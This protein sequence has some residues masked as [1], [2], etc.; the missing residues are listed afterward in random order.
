[1]FY[2]IILTIRFQSYFFQYVSFLLHF[3]IF[4]FYEF[5]LECVDIF[6]LHFLNAFIGVRDAQKSKWERGL[7]DILYRHPV[8]QQFES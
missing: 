4:R 6:V 7:D 3:S 1:M 5:M 8:L 2:I